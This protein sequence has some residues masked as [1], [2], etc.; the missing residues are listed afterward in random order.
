MFTVGPMFERFF[1]SA[2]IENGNRLARQ[3]VGSNAFRT[4]MV[5]QHRMVTVY[6]IVKDAIS[7]FRRSVR[8]H[9]ED[10]ELQDGMDLVLGVCQSPSKPLRAYP[11]AVR[12]ALVFGPSIWT[13]LFALV[14]LV[15]KWKSVSVSTTSFYA[16]PHSNAGFSV[17]RSGSSAFVWGCFHTGMSPETVNSSST[18][19]N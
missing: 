12:W 17:C 5:E 9:C 14:L 13:L 1:E 15:S 19:Q 8:N 2:W 18:H 3:Y 6:S 10:G 4:Y 11:R 16:G 7:F